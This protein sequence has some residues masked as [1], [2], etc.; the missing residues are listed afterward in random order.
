[1]KRASP[2]I[3]GK[4]VSE[5]YFK[6]IPG[7]KDK[8]QCKVCPKVQRIQREGKGYSNLMEHIKTDHKNF[9]DEMLKSNGKL[10][11]KII[12]KYT[13]YLF[14]KL[15]LQDSLFHQKLRIFMVG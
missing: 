13:P 10:E 15:I 1:M 6:P 9:E 2:D 12:I 14:A 7:Q 4:T 8:Y 11:G 3:N 5:F